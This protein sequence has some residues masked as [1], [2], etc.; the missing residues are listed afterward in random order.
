MLKKSNYKLLFIAAFIIFLIFIRSLVLFTPASVESKLSVDENTPAQETRLAGLFIAFENGTTEP[1]VKAILENYN[2]TMYKL[3]Y[4]IDY[5]E[6]RYYIIGDKDK[7]TSVR[8]ELRKEGNYPVSPVVKKG[9][10]YI[11]TLFNSTIH[12]NKALAIFEQNNLQ[13]KKSVL[14]YIQFEDVFKNRI[15]ENDAVKMKD[16]LEMNE[17]VLFVGIEHTTELS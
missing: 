9:N 16:E 12:D 8:D 13:V 15:L 14:C 17:K 5:I 7:I 3:D 6:N 10:Y 1:E 11:I 2:L 4:N